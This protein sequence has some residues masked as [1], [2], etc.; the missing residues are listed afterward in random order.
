VPPSHP[1][2]KCSTF[3]SSRFR[4]RFYRRGVG[5]VQL[6]P[7]RLQ[8]N[9]LHDQAIDA[10]SKSAPSPVCLDLPAL[11]C[12][13]SLRRPRRLHPRHLLS[14]QELSRRSSGIAQKY[15]GRA[16]SVGTEKRLH[17]LMLAASGESSTAKT[18]TMPRFR[19]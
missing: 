7:N 11:T 17:T 9:P 4:P 6:G 10:A 5:S 3:C 12:F 15:S 8:S 14:A 1:H 16:I 18:A 13:V 19:C 2:K